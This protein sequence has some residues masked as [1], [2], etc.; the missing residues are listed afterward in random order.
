VRV[1]ERKE[2]KD[3]LS[4]LKLV[5]NP[6]DSVARKRIE[7]IGKNRA[8]KFDQL[9]EQLDDAGVAGDKDETSLPSLRASSERSDFEDRARGL[10]VKLATLELLDKIL[11]V[12]GYLEYLDDDTDQGKSRVENV[13]ELRS[14]AEEF[15]ILTSFLENV[16]LVQDNQLPEAKTGKQD[17][18]AINL[19]TIH[20]SKGL[21]FPVVFLVGMEEGLFPHSRSMLNPDEMEEERRLAYVGIT[22][23]KDQLYMTYTRSRLYFGSRSN[24]LV[25]RFLTI[26]PDHLVESREKFIESDEFSEDVTKDEDDWLNI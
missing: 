16:A 5:A 11:E 6:K 1:F 19:M 21:E 15:P 26:I 20:S 14:V 18:E 2:I 23:A 24:N 22:R 25:S 17:Q 7:K 8:T 12:T 4:Y 13:K 10:R 3:V 9:I